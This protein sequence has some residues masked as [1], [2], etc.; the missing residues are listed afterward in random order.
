M[1]QVTWPR[2]PPCPYTVK[3]WKILLRWNQKAYVLES[4]YAALSAQVLLSLFKWWPWVD[5]NLFYHKVKFGPLCFFRNYCRLCYKS[6]YKQSTK[7]V[8][9][10]LWIPNVKVIVWPWSKS[11]RF[12]IFKLLFLNNTKPIEAKCHMEPPWDGGMKICSNGPG[13]MTKMAV[14]PVFCK[15]HVELSLAIDLYPSQG[16]LCTL[17]FL[18]TAIYKPQ[19]ET[20]EPFESGSVIM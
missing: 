3:T 12:N 17:W 6:W 2:W 4:L 1:V 14:M 16:E 7:W 8:H 13:H 15:K 20:C 9:E 11:L 19:N 5:L 18:E 10:A